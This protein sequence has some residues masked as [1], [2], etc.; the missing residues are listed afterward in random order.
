MKDQIIWSA[1]EDTKYIQDFHNRIVIKQHS[2]T[3]KTQIKQK[4]KSTNIGIFLCF[5]AFTWNNSV[6]KI[7]M[8]L[9]SH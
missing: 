3:A 8:L 7:L 6:C 5:N 2:I 4:K 1:L 9:N